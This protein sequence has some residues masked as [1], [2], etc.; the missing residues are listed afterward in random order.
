MFAD[1]Y[2]LPAAAWALERPLPCLARAVEEDLIPPA[3]TWS[4]PDGSP[5]VLL[6]ELQPL[7]D[8]AEISCRING[9][10]HDWQLCYNRM[11]L[12]RLLG[13]D[14]FTVGRLLDMAKITPH[15][16]CSKSPVRAPLYS[17]RRFAAACKKY[18][19]PK[20]R[21][22]GTSTILQF[23]IAYGLDKLSFREKVK[24][25]GVIPIKSP[26]NAQPFYRDVDLIDIAWDAPPPA[27]PS[28][29]EP[30]DGLITARTPAR[31]AGM[32]EEAFVAAAAAHGL[33]PR[34]NALHGY[35]VP[36][37]D[38]D[39]AMA[40]AEQLAPPADPVPGD[41][42]PWPCT[43]SPCAYA[44]ISPRPEPPD[45]YPLPVAEAA[46]AAERAGMSSLEFWL[47]LTAGLLPHTITRKRATGEWVYLCN[48]ET[49][50]HA[51]KLASHATK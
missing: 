18:A 32:T 44:D 7:A 23:C 45:N 11:D 16:S 40:L 3:C 1:L 34:T 10:R 5:P 50:K 33:L 35:A 20:W 31:V 2:T 51:E 8:L 28:A 22:P 36:V 15:S 47:H 46:A 39:S 30:S 12:V 25:A 19:P 24:A 48:E 13:M 17:Y 6:Y 26:D 27:L 14:I 29:A 41:Y 38:G 9:R 43:V 49:V 42:G 21:A 4:P 37:F